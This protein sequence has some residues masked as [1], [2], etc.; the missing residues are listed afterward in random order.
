M[1]PDHSITWIVQTVEELENAVKV[2]EKER[3]L[4]VDTEFVRDDTYFGIL[5]LIQICGTTSPNVYCI[6]T[7]TIPK[8]AVIDK[9]II[10]IL[11]K[12]NQPKVFHAATQDID[13]IQYYANYPPFTMSPLFDTSV[14][15]KYLNTTVTVSYSKLISK[16]WKINLDKSQTL[17]D[18]IYRP[19][20]KQQIQYAANDVIYLGKVYENM[21]QELQQRNRLKF[22]ENECKELV[23]RYSQ[24]PSLSN[25]IKTIAKKGGCNTESKKKNL[26][27][28]AAWR[29]FLARNHDVPRKWILTDAQVVHIAIQMD[30]LTK[31][32][33][34]KF[35]IYFENF[36]SRSPIKT[37]S[38][39]ILSMQLKEFVDTND[40]PPY[41]QKEPEKQGKTRKLPKM[42]NIQQFWKERDEF[43]KLYLEKIKVI[44]N[45][46]SIFIGCLINARDLS[47]YLEEDSTFELSELAKM[48]LTDIL[49]EAFCGYLQLIEKYTVIQ[50]DEEEKSDEKDKK[51][52]TKTETNK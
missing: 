17:S 4:C 24:L 35:L 29:E 13:I 20:S 30:Y 11:Y 45:R 6:D 16:Y 52:K 41:K 28:V 26:Y 51:T 9:F 47:K 40:L 14:A 49:R 2:L 25:A 36:H 21:L 5:C 43:K 7:I 39:E 48:Y 19:L 22:V 33:K 18:W 15:W 23:E 27:L 3:Y 32:E 1:E 42:K 38:D 37:I 44:A 46:E 31:K 10:P 50:T 12:S 34:K 8:E